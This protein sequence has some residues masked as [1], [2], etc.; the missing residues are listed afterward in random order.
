MNL[1]LIVDLSRSKHG[2]CHFFSADLRASTP[3]LQH[4][5]RIPEVLVNRDLDRYDNGTTTR[6]VLAD[7]I[8]SWL[9]N[10]EQQEACNDSHH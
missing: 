2:Q 3:N 1:Y 9:K 10:N 7:R 6:A 8:A 4:A 5:D